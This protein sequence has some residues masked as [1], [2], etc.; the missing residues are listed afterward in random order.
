MNVYIYTKYMSPCI[1]L[2]KEG[3][4]GNP[5]KVQMAQKDNT[6]NLTHNKGIKSTLPDWVLQDEYFVNLICDMILESGTIRWMA[7]GL[8]ANAC[9]PQVSCTCCGS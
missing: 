5:E 4:S 6:S 8:I 9:V 3:D 2:L 7:A 1:L